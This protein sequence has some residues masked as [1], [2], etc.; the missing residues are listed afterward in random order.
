MCRPADLPTHQSSLYFILSIILIL[1]TVYVPTCRTAEQVDRWVGR[2]ADRQI[3]RIRTKYRSV[4][5]YIIY[6]Y[7][8]YVYSE[9]EVHLYLTPDLS[10]CRPAD[11]PLILLIILQV[12]LCADLPTILNIHTWL[13]IYYIPRN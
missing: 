11:F 8:M 12:C 2:S 7:A 10:I 9:C 13:I 6:W 5:I 4:S 1:Y 3:N